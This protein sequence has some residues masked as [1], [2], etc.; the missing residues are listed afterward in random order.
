MQKIYRGIEN[1]NEVS[2]GYHGSVGSPSLNIA[3]VNETYLSHL[4][5]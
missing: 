4:T 2:N 1:N 5:E 3:V